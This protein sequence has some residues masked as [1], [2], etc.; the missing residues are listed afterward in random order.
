MKK[1][2]KFLNYKNNLS[3]ILYI[4]LGCIFLYFFINSCLLNTNNLIIENFIAG[5]DPITCMVG[6]TIKCGTE[7]TGFTEFRQAPGTCD[8]AYGILSKN[9]D[10]VKYS[11]CVPEPKPNPD[12]PEKNHAASINASACTILSHRYGQLQDEYSYLDPE[13]GKSCKNY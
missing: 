8:E 9:P 7:T 4:F 5:Q 6:D 12:T 13:T 2:I 11:F 1:F 3:I 10:P